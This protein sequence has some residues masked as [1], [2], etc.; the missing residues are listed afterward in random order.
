MNQKLLIYISESSVNGVAFV[1]M[2]SGELE[3]FNWPNNSL[4]IVCEK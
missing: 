2:G 3:N 1:N 4:K